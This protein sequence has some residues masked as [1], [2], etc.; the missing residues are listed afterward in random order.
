MFLRSF[1]FCILKPKGRDALHVNSYW[2]ATANEQK[3]RPRLDGDIQADVAIIGAGFTGLSAA[4][5]LQNLGFSTVVL[6][7]N[8]VGW[9][10]SGRNGSLMLVGYKH[11]LYALASKY[12]IETTKE[13]LDMSLDGIELVRSISEKHNINCE[14]TKNGSFLAAYKPSH[15]EKLKKEQEYMSREL[16]YEN[17]IVEKK[18][19]ES[20]IHSPLYHGGMIDPNACYLHPLKY[21]IGLADAVEV[22][23]GKIY[24]QTKVTSITRSN[25][26]VTLTTPFGEVKASNVISA[27]NGYTQKVTKKLSRSVIPVGSYILTTQ[28]LGSGVAN[29]LIPSKRGLFDTKKFL[30]YFRMTKDDRLLFG[31]RVNFKANESPE[32]YQLLQKSM[33]EVFPELKQAKIDFTWGGNVALTFDL[34]PHIGQMD[35]GTYFALGYSGHGVSLSTLMGKLLALKITGDESDHN[36]LEK[37]PLKQIPLH[38]QR[39]LVLN[40]VGTYYRFLDWAS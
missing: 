14:F 24:E 28:P 38:D 7:E 3:K 33:L 31:G 18:D 37:F 20:E 1:Y 30:Y 9:G 11:N 23:G 12:G 6:D 13:M 21:A 2:F 26:E 16:K 36:I 15:L 5:H 17:Y 19:V 39:A 34:L 25:G 27:T 32:L 22:S 35:D 40:I 29:R 4:Y 8:C 10:A